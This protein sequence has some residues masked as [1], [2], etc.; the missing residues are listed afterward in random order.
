MAMGLEQSALGTKIEGEVSGD[1]R[2]Q[3][4]QQREGREN[5][6]LKHETINESGSHAGVV[7]LFKSQV[8]KFIFCTTT[9][10]QLVGLTTEKHK[11]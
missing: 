5:L 3:K 6:F 11:R 10:S 4:F 9:P 7:Q 1:H 8:E 2:N